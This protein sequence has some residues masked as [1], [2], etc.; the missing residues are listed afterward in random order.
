MNQT[1]HNVDLENLIAWQALASESWK[2]DWSQILPLLRKHHQTLGF[3]ESCTGGL[4][5][6]SLTSLSGVSDVFMGS[7]VSYANQVKMDFLS[8]D[9]NS[10]KDH[11]AV[12]EQVALEMARGA[13]VKLKCSWALAI[14]GIAGPSG[15]SVEKP[16]GT[17]CFAIC[18]PKFE[19][20]VKQKFS[21]DRAAI[22][23]HSVRFAISML[24][25]ALL[26]L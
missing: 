22:Q 12:S 13:R 6:T 11:G 7:V 5:S 20:S 21:G 18:G 23:V 17:V 9:E 19:A 24:G 16:V 2:K 8:V 25:K 3:A 1:T 26:G 10:L 15:G 4:L 14:T